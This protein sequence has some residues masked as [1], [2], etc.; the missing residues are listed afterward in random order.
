MTKLERAEPRIA[1]LARALGGAIKYSGGVYWL[2]PWC[3]QLTFPAETRPR[4]QL[5]VQLLERVATARASWGSRLDRALRVLGLLRDG[6][7]EFR[8]G[9]IMEVRDRTLDEATMWAPTTVFGH[10]IAE[11]EAQLYLVGL[12]SLSAKSDTAA[13]AIDALEA[14]ARAEY[15]LRA[16]P[17]PAVAGGG[18]SP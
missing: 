17:A 8:H 9:C 6:I 5:A 3:Y 18:Q 10:R 2:S 11:W 4:E 15:E 14:R 16:V 1:E 7:P 12:P 13:G